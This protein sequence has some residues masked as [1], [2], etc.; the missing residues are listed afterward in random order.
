M[1]PLRDC[2]DS[3]LIRFARRRHHF[4]GFSRGKDDASAPVRPGFVAESQLL[5]DRWG[6]S[7]NEDPYFN[8]NL[9]LHRPD[10]SLAYPP[11]HVRRWWEN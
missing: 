8:P 2:P 4:E 7:L 10:F 11:H 1:S 6:E 5:K 9:S 3:R